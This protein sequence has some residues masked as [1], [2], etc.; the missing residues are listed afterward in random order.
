MLTRRAL[1]ASTAALA[2]GC[3]TLE[4]S[5]SV[6]SQS[7]VIDLA[8]ASEVFAGLPEWGYGPNGLE[9]SLKRIVAA[10]EEDT[11][12]PDGP[13][14]ARYTLTPRFMRSEKADPPLQSIDDLIAWYRGLE[15]DLLSVPPFFAHILGERGVILPLDQFISADGY[16]LTEAIYPYLLDHFRSEGGLFALP[17]DASPT[18]IHYDPKI[19]TQ[20]DV[21]L[22]NEGWHW[23]DM[24]EIAGKLT[25]RD[26]N[27]EVRRWGLITQHQGYWWALWQ[28][29]AGLADPIT[30]QC[31]LSE[32]A[33][34]AALQF[35]HD[36]IHAHQV[37]P[38]VT[39]TDA[40]SVFNA[41]PWPPM[42]FSSVQGNWSSENRW[43]A[44]PRGKQFSV[45]VI[46]NM[47]IAITAKAQNT[48]VA[49]K[50]LKGL[51]GVMQRFV[52][53]PAQKEAVAR[54]GDFRKTLRPAE[55][56]AIQ[57]SMEHGRAIP[58]T[59]TMWGAMRAVE[60][61]I[62][63]GD[64]VLTVVNEACAFLQDHG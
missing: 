10:L 36:L 3:S 21:S 37:S 2:A 9:E 20:E 38:P 7:Q 34:I 27:G 47:G 60:E 55:I 58:L 40:W 64:D 54:L 45:P 25:E 39:S 13:A 56:A 22:M 52:E 1:L 14:K 63:R 41:H 24:V 6:P 18:M 17:L 53:V 61:G 46:G 11:E 15:V 19:L 62:V 5:F 30:M 51:A 48:E 35:C 31:R 26:E 49:F 42:F 43:A 50:A 12:N 32:P 29:E 16:E 57:Q 59:R 4:S 8:W 28:N 44:L 33:A 23:D